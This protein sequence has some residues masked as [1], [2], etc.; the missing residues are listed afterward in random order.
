MSRPTFRRRIG[1]AIAALVTP[2][3]D[4]VFDGVNM[5]AHIE[6]QLLNGID[7]LLVCSLIGEGPTLTEAERIRAI[8][9]C[10]ELSE[11]KVP[12][13]VATGTNDTKTT[14]E[15]TI[16]AQRLGADAALV[17]VPYYSKPTQKGIVHH[18]EQLAAQTELPII[19][20]N[21]PSHT[22]VD[23]APATVARLA[24]IRGIIGIADGGCDVSRVDVWRPL[25]PERFGLFT[26][27][28]A[29]ALGFTAGGG[30]GCFSGAANIVP[31]LFQSM[32]HSAACGNVVAAQ[33]IDER[34][35]PLFSA[36]ARESEPAT[37]KHALSLV[38][39]IEAEVRL[40][41]VGVGTETAAAIQ[42]AITLFQ[43]DGSGRFAPRHGYR[44][45]L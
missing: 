26:S 3:R 19:V 34:L 41:L 2:F 43:L 38:R 9:I 1:G 28:D 13:V 20:H 45:G 37:V 42:A 17:T 21:Q 12:V 39:D 15:E 35:Q 24:E 6:W 40:P 31:R 10:I 8:E 29:S 36:L 11:D 32:Q 44:P 5:M 14:L 25:L 7:G 22:A 18:F 16:Q 23:L 4:G 27:N 30:H 33:S